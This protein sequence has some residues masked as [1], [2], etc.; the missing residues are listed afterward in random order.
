MS[1]YKSSPRISPRVEARARVKVLGADEALDE[2]DME[3][4]NLSISGMLCDSG[5]ALTVGRAVRLRLELLESG[6]P[7]QQVTLE[8]IVRRVEGSG[9]FLV[10]F[11]FVGVPAPILE[12]IKRFVVR[13]VQAARS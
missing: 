7:G 10:A 3:T 8:G 12:T 5:I 4:R 1:Q 9:P 11:H 13:R 2:L 6:A